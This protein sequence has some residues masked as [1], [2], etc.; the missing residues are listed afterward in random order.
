[1]N[2][3]HEVDELEVTLIQMMESGNLVADDY[4][5]LSK[6]LKKVKNDLQQGSN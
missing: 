2:H 4:N 3:P 1:M 5:L 6:Y